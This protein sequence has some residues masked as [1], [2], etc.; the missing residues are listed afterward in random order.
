MVAIGFGVLDLLTD[1][2]P[3]LQKQIFPFVTLLAYF[4][5]VI[6]YYY[7]PDIWTYVPHYEKI[8]TPLPRVQGHLSCFAYKKI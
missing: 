2:W 3:T 4:L 6:R 1:R 8:P 7:G 5:L